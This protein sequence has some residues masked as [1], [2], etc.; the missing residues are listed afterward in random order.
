MSP[1]TNE[2]A[3]DGPVTMM[4]SLHAARRTTSCSARRSAATPTSSST[5]GSSGTSARAA[6]GS[7]SRPRAT[8]RSASWRRP[9]PTR[10]CSATRGRSPTTPSSPPSS[11]T[12]RRRPSRSC[13]RRCC[14]TGATRS[15]NLPGPAW[16]SRST[17][18][19][20]GCG[21][22]A[23]WKP[24]ADAQRRRHLEPQLGR[25]RRLHRGLAS[26]PASPTRTPSS[27]S[28]RR[29]SGWTDIAIVGYA[30]SPQPTPVR[31]HRGP[32]PVPRHQRG[33]RPRP[34]I[35]RR[36]HR[37]HLRREL[38]LPVGAPFAF[39][40]N[41]E[42]AGAWPPISESHV[43]MDGAWALYEA[44]VRLQ[45]GDIDIALGVRLGQVVAGRP[46]RGVPPAARPV[47]PGPA[48]RRPGLPGRP[49]GP[50]PARR[51]QGHRA[52]LRRGRGPQPRA[53]PVATPTPSCR[54]TATPTRC[55]AEPYVPA[56]AAPPRPAADLRRGRP[57]WSSPPATRPGRSASG[58]RGS[59]ASTTASSPTS[60]GCGTSP[61][62][63][64]PRLAGRKAGH[65]RR[66]GRRGRAVGATFSPPGAHPATAPSGS[67]PRCTVNPSGGAAG[68]QPGHGRRAGPH[69]RG[70]RRGSAARRRQ[71][72]PG[73]RHQRASA[74]SRT[75]S[76]S[77]REQ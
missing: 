26:R 57:P 14:S 47:L 20:S 60:P 31:A 12:G 17:R 75:W 27:S 10:S 15:M 59:G 61:R 21:S 24:K 53:T 2:P 73:P 74:C 58:R 30:Q 72:G 23:V 38:R 49:P 19:G 7:T 4:D 36:R 41:L 71:P 5:A 52:G 67:A 66:A 45:H 56:A 6:A 16:T 25:R 11:T 1:D 54:A 63:P 76:A 34:G 65:R 50:G 68:R 8:A 55:S 69:R 13:A 33:D 64:R 32:A 29:R 39:V 48:R 18:C 22:P 9:T 44:W 70:G 43:E 40:T 46:G 28:A 35:E 62:R 77:W 42:A 37:V 51:G 3:D